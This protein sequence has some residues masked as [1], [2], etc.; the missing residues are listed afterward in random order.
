MVGI[1]NDESRIVLYDVKVNK[2][3]FKMERSEYPFCAVD[4]NQI[5]DKELLIA[6]SK[7]MYKLDLRTMR[8]SIAVEELRR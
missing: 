7:A 2:S 8:A 6:G 4:F 5:N 3:V 1:I